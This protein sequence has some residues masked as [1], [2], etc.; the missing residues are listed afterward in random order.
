[1]HNGDG[2]SQFEKP[3][4]PSEG[5]LYMII[6]KRK[7]GNGGKEGNGGNRGLGKDPFSI[8]DKGGAPPFPYIL[9]FPKSSGERPLRISSN[10]SS[11]IPSPSSR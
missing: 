8:R 3:D 10:F 6:G 11:D 4:S 1:M 7:M 9:N 5:G 2:A